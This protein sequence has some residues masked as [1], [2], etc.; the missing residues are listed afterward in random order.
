MRVSRDNALLLV[1]DIQTRL[2]PHIVGH[3]ALIRRSRALLAA[4]AMF[5]VPKLLTEHC[6]N[7]IGPVIE[8]LRARF[9]A[10][11]IFEKTCFGAAD[12]PRFVDLAR[13]TARRQVIIAGMEA[14]VCVLQT[15]LGLRDSGFDI[16]IAADAVGSR[17]SAQQDREHALQRLAQAGCR[18]AG[19]ETLLFEWAGSGVD[20]RFRDVLAIVKELQAG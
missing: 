18:L 4:A 2:A 17:Q 8:S 9:A 20:P 7:Q 3:E 5:G 14:H 12:H 6:P 1:V 16:I 10:E 15:A 13:K 11:E 19:T